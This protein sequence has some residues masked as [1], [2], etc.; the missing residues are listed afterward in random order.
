MDDLT[1]LQ[2]TVTRITFFFLSVCFL[3]WALLPAY[4][5]YFSGL[6]IGTITSLLN[7]TFLAWKVRRI[8]NAVVNRTNRRITLGFI[9]RAAIALLAVV[10]TLEYKEINVTAMIVGLL[11]T[12]LVTL[13]LGIKVS[14]RNK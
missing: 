7:Y 1:A 12:Q 11:F 13:V 9:T 3:G 2:K 8:T 14:Q 6:A 5:P 4:A 10:I